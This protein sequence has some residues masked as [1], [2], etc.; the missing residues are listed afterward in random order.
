MANGI[1]RVSDQ[2]SGRLIKKDGFR[3]FYI[4]GKAMGYEFKVASN[5]YRGTYL[6]CIEK[7]EFKIDGNA[8]PPEDV[9]FCLNGKRFK[10]HQLAEIYTE[11]WF[12]L[13]YANIQVNKRGGLEPGEHTIEYNIMTRIPFSG[14]FGDFESTGNV[15]SRTMLLEE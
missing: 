1:S 4:N 15:V 12:V 11:Y 9:V 7:I 6:S 13:D 8:I 5:G 3:N 14:Y 10:V 2:F